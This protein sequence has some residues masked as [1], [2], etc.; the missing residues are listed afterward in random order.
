MRLI[1]CCK[2]PLNLFCLINVTTTYNL[3]G[4]YRLLLMN[5]RNRRPL[6]FSQIKTRIL[7]LLFIFCRQ[8][9]ARLEENNNGYWWMGVVDQPASAKCLTRRVRMSGAMRHIK[10]S[11]LP[12]STI[13]A[14]WRS[15]SRRSASTRRRHASSSAAR[16]M[17]SRS[18]DARSRSFL[19]RSMR[20]CLCAASAMSSRCA[21]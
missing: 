6:I 15:D 11:R 12:S 10:A 20:S 14:N 8:K 19:S 2:L 18:F 4:R 13:R 5:E 16:L 3:N 7:N 9:A 17:R 21:T 1:I